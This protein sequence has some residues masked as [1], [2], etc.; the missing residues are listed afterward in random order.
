MSAVSLTSVTMFLL[1][2]LSGDSKEEKEEG[3][4]IDSQNTSSI[5]EPVSLSKTT[6]KKKSKG[7]RVHSGDISHNQ[8]TSS[9]KGYSSRTHG[10]SLTQPLDLGQVQTQMITMRI[11]KPQK[12]ARKLN[13]QLRL[14]TGA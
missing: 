7:K 4:I 11:T 5:P 2:K 9:K 13:F 14:L 8:G 6:K 3:E 10:L 12:Q 1:K